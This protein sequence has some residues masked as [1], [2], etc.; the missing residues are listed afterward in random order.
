LSELSPQILGTKADRDG[1]GVAPVNDIDTSTHRFLAQLSAQTDELRQRI[2]E[3]RR[4]RDEAAARL[5]ALESRLVNS[6]AAL[7]ALKLYTGDSANGD[8]EAGEFGSLNGEQGASLSIGDGIFHVL[9][10]NGGLLPG[11][12]ARRVKALGVPSSAAS[13]R[14]RL[15]RL[16]KE[17]TVVRDSKSRYSLAYAGSGGTRNR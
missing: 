7:R 12:I 8:D 9:R 16:R 17:G 3:A 6:A 1:E 13:I 15:S 10:A 5:A 2:E 4:Q 14:A 11:E